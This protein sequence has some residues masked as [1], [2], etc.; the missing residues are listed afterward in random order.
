MIISSNWLQSIFLYPA[1]TTIRLPP[2]SLWRSSLPVT[3]GIKQHLKALEAR[4][5]G[6]N[7]MAKS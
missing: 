1:N 3:G 4:H 2:L 6:N 7:R 5:Y